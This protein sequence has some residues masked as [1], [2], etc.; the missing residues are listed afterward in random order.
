MKSFERI[1][2]AVIGA[3]QAGLTISQQLTQLG[4]SHLVLEASDRL[5]GGWLKRWDNFCLVTPN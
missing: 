3:G 4:R 1:D 5:G 2:T